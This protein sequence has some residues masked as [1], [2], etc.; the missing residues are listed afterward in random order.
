MCICKYTIRVYVYM[1]P[2]GTTEANSEVTSNSKFIKFKCA[3]PIA[4][5][6]VYI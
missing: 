4:T 6:K 5:V 3:T 1:S 2:L